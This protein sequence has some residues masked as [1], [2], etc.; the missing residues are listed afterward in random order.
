M[1]KEKPKVLTVKGVCSEL[2]I[3]R[4]HFESKVQSKLTRIT[5]HGKGVKRYFLYDEVM[6]LKKEGVHQDSKYNVIA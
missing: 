4:S 5:R 6:G 3:S 1:N 2:Q